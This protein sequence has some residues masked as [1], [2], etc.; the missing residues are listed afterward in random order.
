MPVVRMDM[1]LITSENSFHD[2][3]AR[4][5]GFP[6]FYGRNMDAWIDCMTYLD[7][8]AAG[9]TNVHTVLPEVMVLQLDH[10]ERFR[11]RTPELFDGLVEMAAFVNWRRLAAGQPAVLALSFYGA[12]PGGES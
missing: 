12:E 5:F 10:V 8:P 1:R 3:F 11:R 6:S 7:D 4:V 2:E 9:M